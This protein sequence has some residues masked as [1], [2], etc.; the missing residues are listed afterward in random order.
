M[1]QETPV[2]ASANRTKLLSIGR[3]W[4]N[5]R[6]NN[7]GTSPAVTIKLDRNLGINITIGAE[8][9]L[10]MFNNE[11]R[12]GKRDADYRVAIALPAE[13]VDREV[14]RQQAASQGAQATATAAVPT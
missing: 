5:D 6:M 9:Q 14:A 13:V 4:I 1:S 11:K 12:E 7:E 3:A 8:T 10:L 2:N